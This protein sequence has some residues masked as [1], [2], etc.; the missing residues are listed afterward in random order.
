MES[1][2][3]EKRPTQAEGAEQEP[4]WRALV[5]TDHSGPGK[6]WEM[7]SHEERKAYMRDVIVPT[8]SELFI[9]FDPEAHRGFG[10]RTCHGPDA[11]ERN[12]AMPN[13]DLFALYPTGS[14]EQKRTVKER[15]EAARF[16]FNA[17]TPTMRK[18]LGQGRFDRS[19][20]EG[21]SCF[22]C[23]PQ[24]QGAP[25]EAAQL[26]DPERARTL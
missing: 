14:P 13:G 24:G 3:G 20:G 23:H 22:R 11:R 21:F 19:T 8:L 26:D 2:G 12:Y 6:P 10:C 5:R 7:M 18:L 17:V 9:A 16:M 1:S 4:S 25:Q 15:E